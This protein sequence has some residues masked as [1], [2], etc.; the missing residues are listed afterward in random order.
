M[1]AK[2]QDQIFAYLNTNPEGKVVFEL[3]QVNKLAFIAFG[4]TLLV[5]DFVDQSQPV[6]KNSLIHSRVTQESLPNLGEI[7]LE[8]EILKL[9]QL[10]TRNSCSKLSKFMV[11]DSA[12]LLVATTT[13]IKLIT[14]SKGDARKL[15]VQESN[16]ETTPYSNDPAVV[17]T[18][19]TE[20]AKLGRVFIGLS[21][22][23]VLELIFESQ[24]KSL[25][26]SQ[27]K[28]IKAVDVSR[29]WAMQLC[30]NLVP[31]W[32]R[33]TMTVKSLEVDEQRNLLYALHE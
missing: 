20:F 14:V 21:S 18:T 10:R 22:G 7:I 17:V 12:V 28:T 8:S 23:E 32:I 16:V 33:T 31:T 29:S 15:K 4:R 26:R 19:I 27:K 11:A 13:D 6:P 24:E 5:W 30:Y 3:S 2:F 25:F 9:V 1:P